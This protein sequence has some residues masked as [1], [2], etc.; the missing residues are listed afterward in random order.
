MEQRLTAVDAF[1]EL[2]DRNPVDF[3]I[4]E[5]MSD[6]ASGPEDCVRAEQDE[7]RMDQWKYEMAQKVGFQNPTEEQIQR[8][9]VYEVICPNW[10]SELVSTSRWSCVNCCSLMLMQQVTKILHQL[11]DIHWNGLTA[12]EKSTYAYR[13]TE[14]GRSSDV[15]PLRT[16][17]DAAINR[18]WYEANKDQYKIVTGDWYQLGNPS[19]WEGVGLDENDA[20]D[21]DNE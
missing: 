8:L 5:M 18:A 20:D 3:I 11:R 6:D 9:K 12:E 1:V 19:E 21:E 4:R 14:S 17:Y 7:E 2:Y 15:P 13:V 16:P 10:R